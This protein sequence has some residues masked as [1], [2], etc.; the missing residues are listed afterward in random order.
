MTEEQKCSE[1]YMMQKSKQEF[2][3]TL[4]ES[5]LLTCSSYLSLP[6]EQVKDIFN[7]ITADILNINY[8]KISIEFT[9]DNSFFFNI[10]LDNQAKAHLEYYL[11][12]ENDVSKEVFFNIFK[13]RKSL[14]TGYGS[15]DEVIKEINYYC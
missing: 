14:K 1:D 3:H 11:E 2:L 15:I 7:S 13:N 6:E 12:T 8:E 10:F 9:Q 5:E 4:L